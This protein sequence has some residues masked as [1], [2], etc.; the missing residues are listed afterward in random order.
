MSV[1]ADEVVDITS[2]LITGYMNSLKGVDLELS[3]R[4]PKVYIIDNYYEFLGSI[5]Y[6][7]FNNEN[8]VINTIAKKVF[9]SLTIYE[10][11]FLFNSNAYKLILNTSEEFFDYISIAWE[12][13]HIKEWEWNKTV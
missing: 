4:D 9:K 12:R 1:L 11:S 3:Y 2:K 7:R 13:S 5:F 6:G 8:E 10:R